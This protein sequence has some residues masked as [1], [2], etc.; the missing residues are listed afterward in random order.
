M[1]QEDLRLS[2][3]QISRDFC[4]LYNLQDQCIHGLARFS[5]LDTQCR[6]SS[7]KYCPV[8]ALDY[9]A[10]H[11]DATVRYC[12]AKNRKTKP[13]TLI[14]LSNDYEH[15]VRFAVAENYECPVEALSI[16]VNDDLAYVRVL[17]LA[18][19]N[20]PDWLRIMSS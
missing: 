15:I 9:L 14:Y 8:E 12:V 1:N 17:A 5:D 20:C 16:L 19:G 11:V 2:D 13:E 18:N 6:I 10:N 4:K 3:E 7:Y